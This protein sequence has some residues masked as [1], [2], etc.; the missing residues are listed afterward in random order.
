[1]KLC[2]S[3]TSPY[4]RK[5]SVTAIET[6]LKTAIEQ[7]PTNVWDPSTDIHMSNPLGKVPALVTLDNMTLYD[8]P[9]ICEHLDSLHDGPKLFPTE[10]LARWTA[11]CQQ[12]L[13]DGILDAAIL[14]LLERRRPE[15]MMR[16]ETWM[17]RQRS[18]VVR[19]LNTLE[20]EVEA[21]SGDITI[22]QISVGCAL[23]YL[24]FRYVDEDWRPGRPILAEW[25]EA[26][27]QR[28][29]MTATVPKDPT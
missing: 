21:L 1:M 18:V 22:G 7:V 4:V 29:S 12:A 10:G 13:A 8:S 25:F 27:D 6:G 26:F 11:L 15:E 24:D 3:P 17:E 28:A 19:A 5:V 16:S 9:V 2:Y 20:D 14:R 23:A